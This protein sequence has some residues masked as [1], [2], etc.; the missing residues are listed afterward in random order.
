M[1]VLMIDWYRYDDTK[2]PT[3]EENRAAAIANAF[4]ML[5]VLHDVTYRYGFTEEKFNF[6]V[7]FLHSSVK[8]LPLTR[9]P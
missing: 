2:D 3:T 5:N 7:W 1:T 4:Y 8:T 6:Q 9:L